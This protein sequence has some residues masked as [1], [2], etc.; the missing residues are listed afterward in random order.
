MFSAVDE[1]HMRRAL[2][3]AALAMNHATPNPRVG[4]VIVRDGIVLAEGF[5]QPPGEPHAEAHAIRSARSRGV[6]LDGATAYV[7]LEPCNHFG[8]TPPCTEGL[9]A[10]G[11]ARVVA[12]MED[13]NPKVSGRGFSRLR[14][15]GIDVRVGLCAHDAIELNIGFIKRMTTGLPWVRCKVA[16]SV[17]G[18]SALSN[19][20]SQWITGPEARRD[21]HYWRARACAILTGCGTVKS[22]DPQMTVRDVLPPLPALTLRQPLRVVFDHLG[23][24]PPTARVLRGGAVVYCADRRPQKLL[25]DV[26]VVSLPDKVNSAKIDMAAALQDLAGRG[27]NELHVEAG[28]RLMGPM[29]AAGL[30]DELLIYLAPKILGR[31]AREMFSLAEPLKLADAVQFDVHDV[32]RVGTDVRMIL[33]AT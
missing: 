7:T 9:V 22:D 23:D 8:R 12:A 6:S 3:L 29:I 25:G 19:G 15:A 2:A 4:C 5:T 21:G 27:V 10:A 18:R 20:E 11:V 30:V 14:E 16:A 24:I 17:D 26:E 1:Q 33:R 31:D 32:T 13:P 28:A